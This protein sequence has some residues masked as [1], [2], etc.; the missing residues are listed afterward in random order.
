MKGAFHTFWKSGLTYK[1]W[2]NLWLNWMR[3]SRLPR[4]LFWYN[5]ESTAQRM[6][7]SFSKWCLAFID[8]STEV[9]INVSSWNAVSS[10]ASN[11][12]FW[13]ILY[14]AYTLIF[15]EP[16]FFFAVSISTFCSRKYPKL[17]SIDGKS[18]SDLFW[19]NRYPYR[20]RKMFIL[21]AFQFWFLFC[22]AFC[23]LCFALFCWLFC[24]RSWY[25]Y[26]F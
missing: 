12:G 19:H 13:S 18:V 7:Q 11:T 14:A 25:E 16:N 24:F 2:Y 9:S 6:H 26:H 15:L 17:G 23:H 21:F 4:N 20:N 8:P 10:I 22:S 5:K 3:Y 1:V